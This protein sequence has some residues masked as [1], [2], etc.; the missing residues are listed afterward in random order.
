MEDR[1]YNFVPHDKPLRYQEGDLTVTRGSAWS[2]PGCHIGCGILLY[3]DKNNKLVKVE[4]DPENPYSQGRLCVRCLGLPE[5]TNHKNRLKYPMKRDPKNRGKDKWE[6]IS[7]DEAYDLIEEKF[8]KIKKEHGAES[9]IFA[10]GTGRDI[11]AYITRLCWSFGSPNYASFLSGGACYLPRVAGMIATTGSF[12]VAD[13]SQQFADRYD[14]PEYKVPETM[15]IWGNYPLT[16][17]SDGFY[18]HWVIDLMKRGMKIVMID[19]KVTWLSARSEE[20]LRVRPG[21][22]AALALGMLNVIINEELYDKKFVDEWCFGFEDLKERVQDF[23]VDK[24]SKITWIPEEKIIKA[25]HILAQSK[26][27]ALQWGV[28]VDMTKEALPAS[29]AIMG[30]FQ[31]TGNID[32]PGGVIVPPEILN[33]AGGWGREL[34]SEEQKAKRIGLDKYPLLQYGFQIAHPDMTMD[35]LETGEPYKIYGAWIQTN[36]PL[37]CM[38]ADPQRIYRCLMDLEFIACVDLFMTPTIMAVADV[39]LPAATFPE[40][41]GIRIGDG[42]QRGETINKVTQIGECKSDMQINLELGKRFNPEAWPWDNVEDMFS[43]MLK[44]TGMTFSELQEKAP[45]YMPF[46]Y[47]RYEKGLLREDGEPGFNTSTGKIELYSGFYEM[48]GLDPLPYFEE[49]SPGP[50]ATPELLEEYPLVLTTGAR[51]W[52]MFHSEHRQVERMR[53]MKPDPTIEVNP[54]T[55]KKLGIQDGDW[56]WVENTRGRAKRRVQATP[57]I[58]PRMCNCDHAWWFPEGDPEKLY[59]VFDLNINNL[60]PFINGK[61]GFGSN[62]KTML[63]KLYKVKE[64]E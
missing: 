38:G 21:T 57:V 36:N 28:A 59:D 45:A 37:T 4:G 22:D 23:P 11:A 49:P 14:N 58:D 12:W 27:A 40:R 39:V 30:L 1:G 10:Q 54:E 64:G 32:I 19:P 41:N 42:C 34:I 9:V 60:V 46:T 33:Y 16:S 62:Y 50:G 18:G 52:S 63:V 53:A 2:G 43:Y 56:V 15:F 13:C 3:T 51:I 47:R 44:Q 17:N 55:L 48:A 24:V 6:R 20:H 61:S 26:P 35:T 29:Q 7:W 31:I 5:V 8:N 25:A